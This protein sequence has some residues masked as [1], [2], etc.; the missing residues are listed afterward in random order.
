VQ[1]S[2]ATAHNSYWKIYSHTSSKSGN[3]ASAT[4]IAKNYFDGTVI[5]AHKK[6]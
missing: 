4:A 3:S 5:A 6:Q 2:S 1:W